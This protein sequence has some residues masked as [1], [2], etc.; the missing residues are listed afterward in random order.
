MIASTVEE[1][2]CILESFDGEQPLSIGNR[3][4]KVCIM[5]HPESGVS[6]GAE[7]IYLPNV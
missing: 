2:V 7:C 1:L 3:Y 5:V 4:G 6:G